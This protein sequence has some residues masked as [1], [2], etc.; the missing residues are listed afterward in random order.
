L[1]GARR[2]NVSEVIVWGVRKREETYMMSTT[3]RIIHTTE[4]SGH[5]ILAGKLDG[6]TVFAS[7]MFG[8]AVRYV[9]D[10]A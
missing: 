4:E 10:E 3:R 2:R 5:S 1:R 6:K 8:D 7:R 9:V